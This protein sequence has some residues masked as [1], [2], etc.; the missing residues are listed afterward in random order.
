M[1]GTV[2]MSFFTVLWMESSEAILAEDICELHLRLY[3]GMQNTEIGLVPL[4]SCSVCPLTDGTEPKRR[5]GPVDAGVAWPGRAG[6]GRIL[7]LSGPF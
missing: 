6:P 2:V 5:P 4:V 7:G 3:A 1:L